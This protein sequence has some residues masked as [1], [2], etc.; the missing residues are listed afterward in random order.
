MITF[1][2]IASFHTPLNTAIQ[3]DILHNILGHFQLNERGL[4]I[5]NRLP[6]GNHQ[7]QEVEALGFTKNDQ[8]VYQI[9]PQPREEERA[10]LLKSLQQTPSF[11]LPHPHNNNAI[12]VTFA[13]ACTLLNLKKAKQTGRGYTITAIEVKPA[14][15]HPR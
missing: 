11:T 6:I 15:R 5:P 7:I 9:S 13:S 1:N 2:D 10:A 8:H 3:L 12:I 14:K 4:L